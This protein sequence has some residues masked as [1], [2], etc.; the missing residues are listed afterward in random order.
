[1]TRFA[2][3]QPMRGKTTEEIKAARAAVVSKYQAQGW[4]FVDTLFEN[5]PKD[6]YETNR[7]FSLWC[8]SESLK[9]MS[10][11]DVVVFLGGWE[12]ARGC[13]IEHDACRAY[14]VRAIEV[15]D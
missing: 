13:K 9:M 7:H 6:V 12:N 1:M 5:V 15:K 4:E 2:V 8:L 3:S 14:G 10:D 11:V